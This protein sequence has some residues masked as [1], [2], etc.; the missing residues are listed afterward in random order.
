VKQEFLEELA[1]LC[2]KNWFVGGSLVNDFEVSF[3][4]ACGTRHCVALNSGT[5]AIRLALL[6]GGI[7]PEDEVVTSPFTFIASAEAISQTGRLVFAD[8]ELDTFN[9]SVEAVRGVLTDQTRGILPVH[10]FGLPAAMESFRSLADDAHCLL[11]EDACQAHGAMVNDRPVGSLGDAAAFSFYPTK[12]LGA[13]G[14]AGALTSSNQKLAERARLLRNHGQVGAYDHEI[15]GFNS[16]MDV[17][18]S[19]VLGLKLEYLEEWNVERRQIVGIY[20]SVLEEV[21]EIRFQN[22]P[23]GYRHVYHVAAALVERRSELTKWLDDRGIETKV[24]YPTPIHLMNAYRNLGYEKGDFP[25][26]EAIAEK[27]LC[28]PVYPG[29]SEKQAAEVAEA[30]RGFYSSTH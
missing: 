13:F 4:D 8:V 19:L 25:N 18:Q 15:E 20:R 26:A 9:L 7:G 16:R 6:A 27:V 28:L 21:G 30:I 22:V 12:N 23:A 29:M 10:I 5:D 3:A 1:Q 2:D 11:I 17:F 14:D 24:I